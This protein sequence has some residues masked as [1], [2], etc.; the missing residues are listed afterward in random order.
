[1]GS[2]ELKRTSQEAELTVHLHTGCSMGEV[3]TGSRMRVET[4]QAHY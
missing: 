2:Q 3:G 1:M 4:L